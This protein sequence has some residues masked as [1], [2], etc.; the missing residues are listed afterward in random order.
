M[1]EQRAP[2]RAPEQAPVR[3][4][5]PVTRIAQLTPH[6][7]RITFSGPEMT[8]FSV[9]GPAEHMKIYFPGP[10]QERPVVPEWGTRLPEGTPRPISRTYTPRHW[11]QD[12]QE[13]DIDFVMHG[14]GPGSDWARSA[15]PGRLAT[16]SAP[17]SAYQIDPS[18]RHYVIAGDDA[19]VP[20]IGTIL[21]TLPAGIR[22][23]VYIEVDD[24]AEEQKL[25]SKADA[26]ITWLHRGPGRDE[27]S[28]R[29]I[30]K[31]IRE[32][33]LPDG[34]RRVFVACEASI[35]R[36]IRRYLLNERQMDR[37]RIYTHGYWKVGE[38]NHP[39]GDRGQDIQ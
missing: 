37:S 29:M 9:G 15:A 1:S 10:G 11:R 18:I 17:K 38:A 19:A 16:L 6:V 5:V 4:T 31:T 7:R 2:E 23:E 22:A 20:A 3:R 24:S 33:K 36:D 13:L 30:E 39:D 25:T 12:A 21:E 14:E 8:G 34:D 27:E 26:E 35:M 28:G 32:L